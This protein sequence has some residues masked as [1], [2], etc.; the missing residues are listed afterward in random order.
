MPSQ[1]PPQ[2]SKVF[3]SWLR[4]CAEGRGESFEQLLSRYPEQRKALRV[5]RCLHRT[6]GDRAQVN[7]NFPPSDRAF[8]SWLKQRFGPE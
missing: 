3:C 8:M 7:R 1:T 5:L 2:S 4:R 6:Y